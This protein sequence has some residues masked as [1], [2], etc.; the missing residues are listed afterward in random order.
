MSTVVRAHQA[1]SALGENPYWIFVSFLYAFIAA[2]IAVRFSSLSSHWSE[3][4]RCRPEWWHVPIWSHLTLAAF[5][6]AMSWLGWTLTFVD[7]DVT[8]LDLRQRRGVIAATSLL[9][10]VDFWVLGTYFA[11]V[12][13]VNDARVSGKYEGSW[14]PHSGLAAYWI[15]WV[16]L[17]YLVWDFLVYFLIPRLDKTTKVEFWKQS[18]MSLFC[19]L[20]AFAAF[21]WLKPVRADRPPWI[22]AADSSLLALLL[23]YRALKQLARSSETAGKQV[24]KLVSLLASNWELW[25]ARVV[26]LLFIVLAV[27]AGA[28]GRRELPVPPGGR[29]EN[30]QPCHEHTS[31]AAG[32][33]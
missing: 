20:L 13:V 29:L 32:P 18:W 15:V 11:F 33:A 5:L 31:D 19:L 25:F 23:F 9:L 14:S 1:P 3:Y 28:Y 16:L 17:A 7:G 12:S 27:L 6:V 21:L 26:L 24:S 30:S 4:A 10:I 22:L 2:D 8:G